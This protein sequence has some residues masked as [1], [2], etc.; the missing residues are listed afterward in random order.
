M[1]SPTPTEDSRPTGPVV[2]VLL[3]TYQGARHLGEQL[4]SIAGQSGVNWRLLVSDDGSSDATLTILAEFAATLSDPGRMVVM[5]GPCKGAAENFRQL[6][7][8]LP[9]GADYAAFCD[10][11]DVWRPDK[12]ARAVE[13][14]AGVPADVPGLYC[15][16]TLI[17]DEDL[18]PMGSSPGVRRPPSFRN[19]LVQNIASGNTMVLNRAGA[20]LIKAANAEAGPIVIHDWWTYQLITGVGGKVI[21]DDQTVLFYRQHAHNE[22]GADVGISAVFGRARRLL[23]GDVGARNRI[24][25]HALA[26]SADRLTIENRA[27]LAEFAHLLGPSRA[28]RLAS[29]RRGRFYRQS[30]ASH[31]ALWLAALLGKL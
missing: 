19:A 6:I 17:C 29:L 7:S 18:R 12:L 27:V 20:T 10:Q 1:Q 4:A 14:L 31:A 8:A 13:A 15:A 24:N 26:D 11:D 25:L 22:I 5:K 28:N 30:R 2:W 23:R 3:A 9:D 16:R 21:F